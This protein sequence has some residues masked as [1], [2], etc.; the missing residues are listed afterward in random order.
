MSDDFNA[1]HA[2]GAITGRSY[3]RFYGP[4][5]L[6]FHSNLLSTITLLLVLITEAYVDSK[7]DTGLVLV[8]H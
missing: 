4:V 8:H 1:G 7:A 2:S 3:R 6:S 5:E